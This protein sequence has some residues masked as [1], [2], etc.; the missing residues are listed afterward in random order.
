MWSLS[1]G[2]PDGIVGSAFSSEV[3]ANRELDRVRED[4]ADDPDI[5]PYVMAVELDPLPEE[6]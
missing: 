2:T 5:F 6:S 4:T 3:E 1:D